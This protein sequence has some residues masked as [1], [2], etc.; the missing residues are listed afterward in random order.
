MEYFRLQEGGSGPE[1]SGSVVAI[2]ENVPMRLEY[3]ITCSHAWETRDVSGTF[4]SGETTRPLDLR[5]DDDHR[6]WSGDTELTQVSGLADVDLSLTPATNLLAVRR[7]DLPAAPM[8]VPIDTTA[9]YVLFP[10]MDV[11]RLR[12][13]YTRMAERRFQYENLIDGFTTE[14]EVDEEGL[15]VEY[16]GLWVRIWPQVPW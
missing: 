4:S 11:T 6:W 15:V 3:R 7:L 9:A 2:E 12:Q 1:L 13:S 5:T 8:G 16:G 10:G 14:I